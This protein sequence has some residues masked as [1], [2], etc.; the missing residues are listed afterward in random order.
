MRYFGS[1]YSTLAQLATIFKARVPRGTF[2][3][4]FGG[5]GTV[6]AYFKTLG[7]R[8]STGDVLLF[9]HCFQV[10]RIR[11]QRMPAFRRVREELGLK[12]GASIIEA[13]TQG[14]RRDGW[15]VQH[16]A[17][18]RKFFTLA[19]AQEVERVWKN[20]LAWRDAGWLS[21]NELAVL[22][23]SLIHAADQV[24]NTAG[25]YYAFL[26]QWH[27]KAERPFRMELLRST[28]G[29]HGG[30]C[31]LG[32]AYTLVAQRKYD[33]LYLDPPYNERSYAHYYH[34][35]ETIARGVRPCVGGM[36]GVPVNGL[37]RSVFNDPNNAATALRKL[38]E[39]ARFR[40]LAFHYADDGIISRV[41][42]R[43]ILNE[44]GRFEEF[45]LQSRGYTTKRIARQVPHR[46]YM[47]KHD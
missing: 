39:T 35:P 3:D 42:V 38:L 17:K 22:M 19:N 16:Y 7:Y 13:L 21:A 32:P 36:A 45:V 18:E 26:K 40:W 4:A 33:L 8:V 6:G 15:F 28:Q 29:S 10:A 1:K 37:E 14:R 41:E 27:R 34:L 12:S 31:H 25:T 24:A 2:C 43:K 44:Y 9:A 5:V 11:C 23:A 47:L 46:L 30:T 20:I